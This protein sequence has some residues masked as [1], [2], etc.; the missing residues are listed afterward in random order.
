[1]VSL[2]PYSQDSII[3]SSSSLNQSLC[4]VRRSNLQICI[5]TPYFYHSDYTH[6]T[7]VISTYR[8]LLSSRIP[9]AHH[10]AVFVEFKVL[11]A[12]PG[13]PGCRHDPRKWAPVMK[14]AVWISGQCT[15]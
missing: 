2:V 12:V 10:L 1:M 4:A 8:L 5:V 9:L 15:A 14:S 3:C 11:V 7:R 13:S 6:F